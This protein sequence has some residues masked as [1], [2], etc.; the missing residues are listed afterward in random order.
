MALKVLVIG[1]LGSIGKRYRAILDYLGVKNIC[2]DT[3]N[4]TG[5][6]HG[7]M[8]VL[9]EEKFTHAIVASPTPTHYRYCMELIGLKIP[10]LCE[11][12]LSADLDQCKKIRDD[13]ASR[14]VKGHVVCNYKFL[15]ERYNVKHKPR[16]Y[17]F[18]NT[19]RDGVEFDCC[20]LIY[21]NPDI[22]LCNTYPVWTLRTDMGDMS[23]AIME[24][25]YVV[26]LKDWLSGGKNCWTLDDGVKMTEAVNGYLSRNSSQK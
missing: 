4:P 3:A 11:K 9:R 19:G 25:Q 15:M 23:Y 16:Y 20:Q 22:T 6:R 8:D 24:H 13:A 21:L 18:Y 14:R 10:F 12:P 5:Y 17:N 2:H 26:M 7:L 1:G